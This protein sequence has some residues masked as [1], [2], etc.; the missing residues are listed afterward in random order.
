MWLARSPP[1]AETGLY[2]PSHLVGGTGGEQLSWPKPTLVGRGGRLLPSSGDDVSGSSLRLS[3]TRRSHVARRARALL[4]APS[5]G[6][7]FLCKF[8]K[9]LGGRL[10]LRAQ[11]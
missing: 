3:S 4:I 8:D 11:S 7:Y 9:G 2:P 10:A 6:A 5:I 1:L